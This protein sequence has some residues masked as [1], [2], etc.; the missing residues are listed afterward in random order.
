MAARPLSS[1]TIAFGLVSIPVKLYSA[2]ESAASVHFNQIDR[3]DGSRIKQ[4]LISAKTG[5]I[6]PKDEIVKGYEFAKN[7][8]VLFT[9]EE[10]KALEVTASS[11]IKVDEF[12]PADSVDR[13]Y[14]DKAYYLAPDKGGAG[15]YAL[16]SE[17]LKVTKRVAI[18]RYAARG[19]Q[20]LV[21]VR[22]KDGGLL[23]EQLHYAD[24]I[25]AFSEIP[26]DKVE[27]R[28]AE[29]QLA[30][31]LIDQL[32]SEKFEPTRYR[33]EVRE[34]VMALIERKVQGE[35]IS[36]APT[37]QPEHKIVDLM[38]ALKASLSAAGERK[39]PHGASVPAEAEASE[40]NAKPKAKKATRKKR[41]VS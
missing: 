24:E 10:L 13:I 22:P 19:R 35:S 25:R 37:E 34:Q 12:V 39:A 32:T 21:A 20:Y 2:A 14:F 5:E 41:A 23:L 26:L 4:Q 31:M 38:E 7:Q 29:L 28:D 8:Y 3:R 27:I 17:A 9:A 1:A 30:K 18:G 36:V 15:A 33:D 16:F 40:S 6:V 11:S